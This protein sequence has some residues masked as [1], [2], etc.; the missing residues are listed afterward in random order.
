MSEEEDNGVEYETQADGFQLNVLG[1]VVHAEVV[2]QGQYY[3][4]WQGGHSS[5]L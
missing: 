1:G 3:I 5:D 2:T 4:I